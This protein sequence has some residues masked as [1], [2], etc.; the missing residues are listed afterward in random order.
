[1][2][3]NHK[4]IEKKWKYFWNEYN[5]FKT[6]NN[7]GLNYYVL[8]MFLYPSGKI[9]MGHVRNY[10]IGDVISRLKKLQGYNVLHPMGWDSYGL[11]AENAAI[12]HN[13]HPKIWTKN[14]IHEMKIQLKNLGLS[15]DWKREIDTS[16]ISYFKHEQ[17]IFIDFFNIGIAYKK[18]SI[19]NWDVIDNTVLA[20][21]QVVNGKGWRSGS[22][23]KKKILKQWFLKISSY[24]KK[25]LKGLNYLKKWPGNIKIMQK[26]WIGK[27]IGIKIKYN[28]NLINCIINVF[29][30]KIENIFSISSII[31]P[32]NFR[33]LQHLN[34][35]YRKIV[36][37]MLKKSKIQAF[38][39]GYSVFHPINMKKKIPIYM[40]NRKIIEK[41]IKAIFCSPSNNLKDFY[42]SLKYR[43]NIIFNIIHN[44]KKQILNKPYFKFKGIIVNSFFFN[45]LNVY[46]KKIRIIHYKKINDFGSIKYTYCI[47]DWGIS[48]QRYWGCPIPIIYCQ[49]CDLISIKK[50]NLPLLLPISINLNNGNSLYNHPYWKYTKCLKCLKYALKETDTFDTFFESS[51]YF[52]RFC[53]INQIYCFKKELTKNWLPVSTYIGG[54]EHAIM[55][56]L[57]SRF[58]VKA[59]KKCNYLNISEPFINLIIQ[60]MIC[61]KVFLDKK[62]NFF[63][64]KETY[65]FNSIYKKII[66]N[67]CVITINKEKMS[68]SKNNI[69][70]PNN[71]INIY[72]VDSIRLFILSNSPINNDIEWSKEGIKS[73]NKYINKL[74]YFIFS[75][76]KNKSNNNNDDDRKINILFKKT[77][78]IIDKYFKLYHFH[79]T[80]SNLRQLNKTLLFSNLSYYM[81][82][83]IIKNIAIIFSVV[84]PYLCDEI[85]QFFQDKNF[86][87]QINWPYINYKINK[88]K[89]CNIIIQINGKTRLV[90]NL[91]I[92]LS[93]NLIV[94]KIK[95]IIFKKFFFIN[96]FLK[97]IIFIK[98]IVINVIYF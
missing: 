56:L 22:L 33:L 45:L 67:S 40:V 64:P 76:I 93:K 49:Y 83:K 28:I 66:D 78:I 55:H 89:F 87:Y 26:N 62:N 59:L 31:I 79:K 4:K 63:S 88:I 30:K 14:N 37:S 23:V 81:K 18:K 21:E 32:Y 43:F 19:V 95:L 71:I 29:I 82:R 68:K 10:T 36:F 17:S 44:I 35:F 96:N 73:V 84:I 11:P 92:Y 13:I 6:Y 16:K 3:I 53:D 72:G 50:R 74:Y 5:I 24:S 85:W 90:K 86:T 34:V 27:E 20:N 7:I 65:K 46:K 9:H 77:I 41:K 54:I 61:H 42:L 39:I 57:Y 80:I 1:M 48:R 2:L 25:L 58:F 38:F 60:G 70:C 12:I 98:N 94:K 47:K 69:I 52:I 75:L 91:E 8:E 15:Y 51:W 97:K